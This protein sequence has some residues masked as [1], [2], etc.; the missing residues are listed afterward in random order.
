MKYGIICRILGI[1]HI[2]APF[3]RVRSERA[4]TGIPISLIIRGMM[5]IAYDTGSRRFIDEYTGISRFLTKSLIY[6][7]PPSPNINSFILSEYRR[8]SR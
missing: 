2:H 6:I 3:P 4:G 7:M 5:F 1:Y 8:M